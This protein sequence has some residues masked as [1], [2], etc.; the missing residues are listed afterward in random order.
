MH[1]QQRLAHLFPS[2][3]V[4]KAASLSQ[5][6]VKQ[7]FNTYTNQQPCGRH[8][9]VYLSGKHMPTQPHQKQHM[10]VLRTLLLLKSGTL[11]V[12]EETRLPPPQGFSSI[13]V[14]CT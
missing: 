9:G 4:N 2:W 3:L 1:F 7:G 13:N 12:C 11:S 8:H 6:L 5:H 10:L 14:I